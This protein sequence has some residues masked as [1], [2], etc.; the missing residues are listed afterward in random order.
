MAYQQNNQYLDDYINQFRQAVGREPTSD[1][2][3]QITR[4]GN[5]LDPNGLGSVISE[6]KN[7]PNQ[8]GNQPNS[9]MP[10]IPGF[11]PSQGAS[12]ANGA[13]QSQTMS[14]GLAAIPGITDQPFYTPG[15]EALMGGFRG[16]TDVTQG[17]E[18]YANQFGSMFKNLTGNDPSSQDWESFWKMVPGSFRSTGGFQGTSYSDMNNLVKDYIGTQYQPQEQAYQTSQLEKQSQDAINKS[19]Q[20]NVDYLTNPQIAEQLK[21]SFNQGG[22]LDSGAYSEGIGNTLAQ[23]ASQTQMNNI[24]NNLLPSIQSMNPLAQQYASPSGTSMA[25]FNRRQSMAQDLANQ[26]SPSALQQWAPIISGGLQAAGKARG[27]TFLCTKL[28][29]LGLAYQEEIQMVHDKLFPVFMNHPLDLLAYFIVAP[30][31]ISKA[32]GFDWKSLKSRIVD[33]IIE[34]EDPE[35]AFNHYK[36]VCKEIFPQV[37]TDIKTFCQEA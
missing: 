10:S 19:T 18:Q 28:K 32:E 27:G 23:G 30:I 8:P 33:Q 34:I 14:N 3:Q 31:F 5:S 35:I 15:A 29:E 26:A 4:V 24:L 6:A 21:N 13:P 12:G 22:M 16:N 36:S 25:Q 9:G 7:S 17:M 37:L 20:A 1:E 2:M 11:N